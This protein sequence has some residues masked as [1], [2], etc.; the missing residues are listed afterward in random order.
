MVRRIAVRIISGSRRGK[1][2]IA[3][4]GANTR[5]TTDRVKE[6]VFNIIQG[7]LPTERVLDLFAG[8]GALGIEALSRGCASA[9][10]V[11]T[12]RDALSVTEQNIKNSQFEKQST[13][14]RT[15]ATAYLEKCTEHFDIIF[16]DPPYN[17]GLLT[18]AAGL[19]EK[20][21]LLSEGGI[22]V[23]E[24]ELSGEE[25]VL[26]TLKLIRSATYGKTSILIYRR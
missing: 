21:E 11:D 13:V 1:K 6:S 16:L 24:T 12:G 7:Y 26:T 15:D 17:T 2:L 3:P 18:Q 20:R 14:L 10:F 23:C 25:P 5:P 8:S 19:I 4:A 9:V 22:M